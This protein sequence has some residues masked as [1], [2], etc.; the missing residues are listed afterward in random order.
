MSLPEPAITTAKLPT[1][2]EPSALARAWRGWP[3]W[4]ARLAVAI[5][6]FVWLANRV[7]FD[8]IFEHAR[9]VGGASLALSIVALLFAAWPAS[10]RWTILLRAYGAKTTPPHRE[11]IRH[12]FVCAYFNALP[13]GV[14]GDLIRAHRVRE[15]LPTL[16]TSYAVVFVE[17]ITGLLGLLIL[18]T[19]AT[20]VGRGSGIDGA[21]VTTAFLATTTIALAASSVLFVFPYAI[22]RYPT[23][24]RNLG[25]LPVFGKVALGIPKPRSALGL[26]KAVLLSLATQGA[27]LLGITLLTRPLVEASQLVGCVQVMP[28]AILLTYIPLT[29]GG[30]AQREAIYAY[31]YA[32]AGVA[33]AVAV[34][35]SLLFFAAQMAMAAIGGLVHL[36]EKLLAKNP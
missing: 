31:L 12:I 10:M 1:R 21:F 22:E 20:I 5:L 4:V 23:L 9:A 17:R 32:F 11:L 14:A 27:S 25:R 28:L 8:E 34:A 30:I 35:V 3:G 33:P 15:H 16:A 2:E 6:P 19:I 29:P 36:G 7:T 13:S 18:A 26:A 24:R